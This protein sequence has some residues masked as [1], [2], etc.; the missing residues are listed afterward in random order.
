[1]TRAELLDYLDVTLSQAAHGPPQGPRPQGT[2]VGGV[3]G[4][5]SGLRLVAPDG[6]IFY[7]AVLGYHDFREPGPQQD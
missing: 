2:F 3:S 5:A 1:M 6:T 4:T 7:L